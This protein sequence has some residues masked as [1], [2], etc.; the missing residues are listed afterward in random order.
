MQSY[1]CEGGG[2]ARSSPWKVK[3]ISQG[4]ESFYSDNCAGTTEQTKSRKER[5]LQKVEKK[6]PPA[7]Q[8]TSYFW[9]GKKREASPLEEKKPAS[10]FTLGPVSRF[11]STH[12]CRKGGRKPSISEK[13]TSHFGAIALPHPNKEGRKKKKKGT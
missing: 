8:E 13:R 9:E 2:I 4:K 6:S 3:G 7:A 10:M 1:F 12:S 5:S 11:S